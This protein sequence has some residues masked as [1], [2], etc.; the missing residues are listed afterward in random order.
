MRG[1]LDRQVEISLA[2]I[3]ANEEDRGRNDG[4]Q[5]DVLNSPK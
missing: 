4:D 2:A 1:K 3:C 5:K